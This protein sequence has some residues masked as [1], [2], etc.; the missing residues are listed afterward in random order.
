MGTSRDQNE[1]RNESGEVNQSEDII[2]NIFWNPQNSQ[3]DQQ[4]DRTE[5]IR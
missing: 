5:R 1:G 4:D 3:E 2:V